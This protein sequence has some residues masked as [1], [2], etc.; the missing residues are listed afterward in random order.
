MN[1]IK[2]VVAIA[3]LIEGKEPTVEVNGESIGGD[4]Y[5]VSIQVILDD[6]AFLLKPKDNEVVWL[7]Q[8]IHKP[9]AW[10]KNL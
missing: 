1:S 10:P 2:N 6:V 7:Q 4:C 9:M 3:T 5:Y 8:V